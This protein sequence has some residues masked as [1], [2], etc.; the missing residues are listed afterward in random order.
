MKP[1][2]SAVKCSLSLAA[3]LLSPIARAEPTPEAAL[4]DPGPPPPRFARVRT[5]AFG[6]AGGGAIGQAYTL[7]ALIATGA[8]VVCAT[9][10]DG[11]QGCDMKPTPAAYRELYIPLVGPWLALRRDDVNGSTGYALLFG[12]LGVVQGAGLVLIAYDLLVPRYTMKQVANVRVD[13]VAGSN[14]GLLTLSGRF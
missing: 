12:G 9:S 7:G 14:G 4:V 3:L 11:D 5:H 13:A 6:I 8:L 2:R 1:V 10:S